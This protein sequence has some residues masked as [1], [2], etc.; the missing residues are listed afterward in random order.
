MFHAINAWLAGLA[1]RVYDARLAHDDQI[2]AAN[3]WQVQRVAT[4]TRRYR[5]PRF[6]LVTVGHTSDGRA[7]AVDM[8]T[9]AI[10]AIQPPADTAGRWV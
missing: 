7:V 10:V 1:R 3:Q 4:S 6:D 8:T 5:D 2:A 9:G